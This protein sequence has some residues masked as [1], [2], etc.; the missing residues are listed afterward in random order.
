MP[1]MLLNMMILKYRFC[2]DFPSSI[3]SSAIN[4][5]A[6]VSCALDPVHCAL[7][8]KSANECYTTKKTLNIM[9]QLYPQFEPHP[10][11]IYIL[12]DTR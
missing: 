11:Y 10:D 9:Y 12:P 4:S 7:L 5:C 2:S 6:A 8:T 1:K 3:Q